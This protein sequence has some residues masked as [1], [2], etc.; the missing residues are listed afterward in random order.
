MR[1]LLRWA[2]LVA[3]GAV[4]GAVGAARLHHYNFPLFLAILLA[5][6]LV[7]VVVIL[8]TRGDEAP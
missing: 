6:S 8:L 3:S 5:L 7:A 1:S 2:S 4:L